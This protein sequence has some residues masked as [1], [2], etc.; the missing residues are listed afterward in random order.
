MAFIGWLGGLGG[1]LGDAWLMCEEIES[2]GVQ[3]MYFW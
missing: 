1:L 2:S 3:G